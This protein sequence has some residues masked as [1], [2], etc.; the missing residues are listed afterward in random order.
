MKPA[1]KNIN[2]F[3]PHLSQLNKYLPSFPPDTV[4]QKV[5][6]LNEDKRKGVLYIAMSDS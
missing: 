2:D 1:D 3:T 4:G 6:A 5:G